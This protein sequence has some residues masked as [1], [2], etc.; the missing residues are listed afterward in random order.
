MYKVTSCIAMEADKTVNYICFDLNGELQF[1]VHNFRTWYLEKLQIFALPLSLMSQSIP[2][3]YIPPGQPSPW[4]IL[5]ASDSQ[6]RRQFFLSNSMPLGQKMMVEF[7][8]M[9]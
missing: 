1:R 2:T 8:G 6:P 5:C 4:K 9:G 7:S 3:E